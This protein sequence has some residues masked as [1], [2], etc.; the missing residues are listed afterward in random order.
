MQPS[1][2][3]NTNHWLVGQQTHC[4][5]TSRPTKI[6]VHVNLL[7]PELN[8]NREDFKKFAPRDTEENMTYFEEIVHRHIGKGQHVDILYN[9]NT[10]N[11]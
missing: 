4:T 11:E 10:Y 6:N 8:F 7:H 3:C 9:L 5:Q 1:Q 2:E